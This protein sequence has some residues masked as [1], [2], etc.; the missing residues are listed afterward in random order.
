[1]PVAPDDTTREAELAV[2][3][4]VLNTQHARL[5]RSTAEALRDGEWFGS[6]VHSVEHW[7][8]IHM[9]VSVSNA[10]HIAACA[11]RYSE[12]PLLMG[13][14][15]R[16]ELSLD[17][18]HA[19]VA[20]APAWADARVT[21]FALAATVAQ[22]RRMIRDENFEGDPDEPD[23][24]PPS[25]ERA[26]AFGWDEHSRL[27]L[28][29]CLDTEQGQLVEGA[30]N[31]ARDALFREGDEHVTW[32]DALAEIARRSLAATG[33][34]RAE[35]FVPVVHV[36]VETGAVQLTNG[37]PVPPGLRDYAM[38]VSDLRPVWER[39]GIPLAYGRTQRTVPPKLRRL[40]EHRDQGCRVPGCSARHGEV[41][42]IVH[43]RDGGVTESWNL[44]VL[45]KRHHKL[46]HLGKLR[47]SGN[48]DVAAGVCFAD[49]AGRPLATHP[50]PTPPVGPP[51]TPQVGYQH[52]SGERLRRDWVG[53]GWS[54]PNALRRRR[55]QSRVVHAQGRDWE[56]R[57]NSPPV[58]GATSPP[59]ASDTQQLERPLTAGPRTT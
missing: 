43:W 41:H 48:A 23:P 42:H 12:F 3:A 58:T 9:G 34:D 30:L 24:Q 18:V 36:H 28:S 55:E 45:C 11:R 38:C 15:E 21:E 49:A 6:Q 14:F 54:H 53:L 2:I 57:A 25:S 20:K 37:V 8:T 19:V 17:Q 59:I 32:A 39:D 13:A 31:E 10:K 52:P 4:G 47:I 27:W 56:R 26:L 22:L 29:G 40:V 44:I 46:H 7:L 5:V 33:R 35:R 50:R 1:M 51:P 16:G